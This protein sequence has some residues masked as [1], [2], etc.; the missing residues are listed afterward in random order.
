MKSYAAKPT[1]KK[2]AYKPSPSYKALQDEFDFIDNSRRLKNS[3]R[4]PTSTDIPFD[5]A[6]MTL[7]KTDP[8][9]TRYY[10]PRYAPAVV[11]RH[12]KAGTPVRK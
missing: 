3:G 6:E 4:N 1:T 8:D 12:S 10:R 5:I 11:T 7:F 9:G 2:Q